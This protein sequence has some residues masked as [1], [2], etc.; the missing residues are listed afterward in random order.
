MLKKMKKPAL[1]SLLAALFLVLGA[2]SNSKDDKENMSGMDH[3]NMSD[4]E[5]EDSGSD[6]NSGGME[7]MNHSGDGEIPEG[8]EEAQ[9][10]TYP[11]GSQAIITA[12]HMDGMNGAEATIVGAYSTT[13]YSVTYTP[14]TGGEKVEDHKWV[15]HQELGNSGD[16]PYNVG[17][18]VVLN[19]DHMEGMDGATATVDTAEQTTI[20]MVDYKDTKTG[21][22]VTNHQWVTESELS[23]K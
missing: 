13:V 18:E 2:C 21:E 19:A 10:P 16:T 14:T 4:S 3:S 5:T 9:N 7:G 8:L 20:Y 17:D 12:D 22:E 6:D 1:L 23:A 11:V 15:I